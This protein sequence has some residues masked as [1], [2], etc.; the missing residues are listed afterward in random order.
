MKKLILT[1]LLCFCISAYA[2][3]WKKVYEDTEGAIYYVDVDSLKKR[4]GFVYYWQLVDYP[5]PVRADDSRVVSSSIDKF[6][7]DCEI[8]KRTWLST[9][10]Y[11]Q[12]IVPLEKNPFISV[13]SGR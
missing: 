9:T 13:F 2:F 1:A 3:N 8:E 7:V 4:N 10:D 12:S 6:K 5:E 11:S